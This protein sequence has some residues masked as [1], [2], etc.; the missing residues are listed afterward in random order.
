MFLGGMFIIN[1]P[2]P[3]WAIIKNIDGFAGIKPVPYPKPISDGSYNLRINPRQYEKFQ[4]NLLKSMTDEERQQLADEE[5]AEKAKKRAQNQ[6]RRD[7]MPEKLE[8]LVSKQDR[9]F[10]I[11][12]LHVCLKILHSLHPWMQ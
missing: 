3:T 11:K 7:S 8:G 4:D 2:G 9:M 1:I 10:Q 12:I 5:E 6:A